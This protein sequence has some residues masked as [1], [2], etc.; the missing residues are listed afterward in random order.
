MTHLS[1]SATAITVGVLAIG[2]RYGHP[3]CSPK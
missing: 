3:Q 1:K 2:L